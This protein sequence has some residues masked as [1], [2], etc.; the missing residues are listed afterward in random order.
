MGS[1]IAVALITAALAAC[2]GS[3]RTGATP[4][5]TGSAPA[6]GSAAIVPA[7]PSIITEGRAAEEHLGERVEVRGTAK[8]AK[9]S[10]VVVAGDLIVYCLGVDSWPSAIANS[11]VA[12]HGTLEQTSEFAA[13]QDG[14]SAGTAGAVYVLR[15]CEYQASQ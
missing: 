5:P 8:N 2:T 15:S 6:P 7:T 4:P 11:Q 14:E 3:T 12:A 13:P 1:R 10:A 9:I